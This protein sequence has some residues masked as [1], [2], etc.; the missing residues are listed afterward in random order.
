MQELVAKYCFVI[1]FMADMLGF[2]QDFNK[3]HEFISGSY[4]KAKETY[5]CNLEASIKLFDST[6]LAA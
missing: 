4:R 2:V 3:Q 1:K 5:L 6:A